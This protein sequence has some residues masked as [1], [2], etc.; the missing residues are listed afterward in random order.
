M[1][2]QLLKNILS[3]ILTTILFSA[4]VNAQIV[5]TDVNPD[6]V[7]SCDFLTYSC[8]GSH[9]LDLN[10]DGV[11]DFVLEPLRRGVS[12][13][14][15]CSLALASTDRD[16]AVIRSTSQSWIADTT[17]GFGLNAQ[18]DSSLN[19]TNINHVLASSLPECQNCT[20][21]GSTLVFPPASGPWLN[22][23][24]KY[25]P[26]KIKIGSDFYYGW[27]RLAV[28]IPSP[29]KITMRIFSYAY[30]SLPNQ[31]ILAGQTITTTID[32]NSFSSSINLFPNPADSHFTI[33]LGSNNQKVE[34]TI[35]DITGKIIY[36]TVARNT[37]HLEV[38]TEDFDAGMYVVQIKSA[39]FIATK[40][41]IIR[42]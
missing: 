30:N 21:R 14:A 40:K 33:A 25:L 12:C 8:T 24:G 39:G 32:E 22:I 9:S 15:G 4:G 10:N 11:T 3:C 1:K 23:S 28:I 38:N 18:I 41:M 31:P 27:I 13:G 2:K 26:L 7:L 36:A 34:V 20:F 37:Q 29:G 6:V 17:G 35:T 5:Y 19:W 42:K 16:S